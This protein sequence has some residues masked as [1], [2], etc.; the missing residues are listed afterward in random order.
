M[1]RR[2]KFN[3]E[4]KT[5]ESFAG[6]CQITAHGKAKDTENAE[7]ALYREIEEEL[8][9]SAMLTILNHWNQAVMLKKLEEPEK[10]V[11][12]YGLYLENPDIICNLTLTAGTGGLEIVDSTSF[13]T[14]VKELTKADKALGITDTNTIA[15][16]ADE[17]EA[18]RLAFQKLKAP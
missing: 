3:P 17:I 8:G 2:G 6:A 15:M 12:S 13:E 10:Q 5:R 11:L 9:R 7:Q 1:Q 18:V 14:R 16:F 4:T